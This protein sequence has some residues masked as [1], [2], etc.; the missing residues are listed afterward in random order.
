MK[1]LVTGSSGTIGTRLCERLMAAGHAVHGAD[2]R[3]NEWSPEINRQTTAVDLRHWEEVSKKLPADAELIVHLA[4]NARV[5]DLVVKP[6]EAM[7]NI[8]M[9]FNVL[10]FA[11]QKGIK[12]VMFASSREVYGNIPGMTHKES[13][14]NIDE[15]ESPYAASKIAGEVLMRSYDKCYGIRAV[16]FRF[17]NVYGMYDTSNRLVPQLIRQA[18]ASAAITLYDPSKTLDF[19][20][21]DDC[22][23]GVMLAIDKFGVCA[24]QTINLAYGTGTTLQAVCDTILKLTGSKSTVQAAASRTGEVRNYVADL[25]KAGKL[26][27]YK[28]AVKIEEGLRRSLEWWDSTF[29]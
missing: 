22:V 10:E 17:S 20:Y 23:G 8:T 2:I 25:E 11:R 28:P 7:D 3:P 29:K 24:G 12:K 15:C 1:I 9:A 18:R 14:A 6:S 27:K 26:L 4:A 5:Y 21:I 13:E 16:I 19:T